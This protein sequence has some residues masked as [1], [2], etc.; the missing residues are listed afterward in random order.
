MHDKFSDCLC[1]MRFS[2][3]KGET[4]IWISLNVEQIVYEYIAVYVNDLAIADVN[5]Q[6]IIETLTYKYHFKLKWIGTKSYQLNI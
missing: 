5:S 6:K 2:L 4:D 1:E 3:W